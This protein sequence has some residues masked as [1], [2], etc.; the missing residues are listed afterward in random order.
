MKAVLAAAAAPRRMA[1]MRPHTR[2]T[3]WHLSDSFWIAQTRKTV[4]IIMHIYI[5]TQKKTAFNIV[6]YV[7][8]IQAY[9]YAQEQRFQADNNRHPGV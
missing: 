2:D 4:L 5:R 6:F 8:V 3:R 1:C 7:A 9:F